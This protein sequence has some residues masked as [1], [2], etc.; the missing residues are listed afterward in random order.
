MLVHPFLFRTRNIGFQGLVSILDI[1]IIRSLIV[2]FRNGH[3]FSNVRKV[4]MSPLYW[5]PSARKGE[6]NAT[7]S[8]LMFMLFS[9]S[10][11]VLVLKHMR[12]L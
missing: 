12:M 7:M 5:C 10:D 4:V 9:G 3:E 2:P 1:L 8:Q 6:T 11:E